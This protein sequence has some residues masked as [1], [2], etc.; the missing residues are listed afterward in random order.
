M[1]LEP[2]P[3]PF[4]G[5]E[6]WAYRI[7]ACPQETVAQQK[8][9][10]AAMRNWPSAILYPE[11]LLANPHM[12]TERVAQQDRTVK[13]VDHLMF[14]V[15]TVWFNGGASGYTVKVQNH[16]FE[17][18]RM[19]PESFDVGGQGRASHVPRTVMRW[20]MEQPNQ[21]V[22]LVS[23]KRVFNASDVKLTEFLPWIR[24]GSQEDSNFSMNML[25][26][27]RRDAYSFG[28][29]MLYHMGQMYPSDTVLRGLDRLSFYDRM[30]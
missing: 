23:E 25:F 29:A 22:R 21:I 4:V 28:Q 7:L 18:V 30:K 14:R 24:K 5:P 9:L 2:K 17:K 26:G 10:A 8:L 6:H 11:Q 1:K 3:N 13:S 19:R 27:D 12:E 15:W 16:R 20:D